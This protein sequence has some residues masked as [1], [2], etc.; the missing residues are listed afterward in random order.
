MTARRSIF[1]RE[2][3]RIPVYEWID[4][5]PDNA[6]ARI[7]GRIELLEQFGHELRRPHA[8]YLREGIWELRAKAGR[9]NLRI[10]Y[11]FHGADAVVLLSGLTKQEARIPD[12]EINLAVQRLAA[13]RSN[14]VIHSYLRRR[15]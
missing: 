8:D 1:F 2:G 3:E 9:L 15:Q 5:L 4:S 7:L 14:P 10:L 13:F 12:R 11:G 6:R